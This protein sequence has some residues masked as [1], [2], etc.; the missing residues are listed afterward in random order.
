MTAPVARIRSRIAIVG[1]EGAIGIF[2]RTIRT[3]GC[4]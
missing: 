4:L 1:G 2:G 3:V